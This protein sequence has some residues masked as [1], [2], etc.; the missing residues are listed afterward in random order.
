[1]TV[2]ELIALLQQQDPHATPVLWGATVTG[3]LT[4]CMLMAGE[5]LPVQFGTYQDLGRV[6]LEPWD[7]ADARLAGPFP[8]VALGM[9]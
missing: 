1:M 2:A 3:H 4:L 8:G 9:P 7:P 5:V 6:W